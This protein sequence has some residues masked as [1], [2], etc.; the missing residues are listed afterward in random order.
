MIYI[1][2][3]NFVK[4]FLHYITI[5]LQKPF[6]CTTDTRINNQNSSRSI[7]QIRM[8]CNDFKVI[9]KVLV[10][11]GIPKSVTI[12]RDFNNKKNVVGI[13][14]GKKLIKIL[15]RTELLERIR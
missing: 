4:I 2:I 3:I 11:C 9:C 6:Y 1:N 10:L 8:Q 5:M 12:I 15:K 14:N 7:K 13:S